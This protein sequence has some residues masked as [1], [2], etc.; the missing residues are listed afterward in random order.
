MKTELLILISEAMVVYFLRSGR[1]PCVT[2][3][4]WPIFYA[5]IG[6]ITAVMSWVTDAGVTVQIAG[7]TFMVGSTVFYTSLLLAS[8]AVYIFDGPHATR[9]AISTVAG[10]SAMVPLIALTL[11]LQTRFI[12]C[13]PSRT[14]PSRA[15]GS[16]R[17][18]WPTTRADLI[19][20]A[21]AWEFLAKRGSTGLWL[22]AFVTLLGVMWLDV[23][24]RNGCLPG[25]SR[26]RSTS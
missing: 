26:L 4:G 10:V 1:I 6:G 20:L 22:R 14:S 21:M 17:L 25:Q 23:L 18:R 7:I 5:L 2:G 12:K 13:Q 9:V 24:L 8:L 19:F 11:H 15:S 3:S 16:T